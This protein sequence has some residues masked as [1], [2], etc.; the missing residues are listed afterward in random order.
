MILMSFSGI[1]GI[2]FQDSVEKKRAPILTL[3]SFF[4]NGHCVS[5][6][7]QKSIYRKKW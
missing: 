7:G 5:E 2:F 1:F 6:V 3:L 4:S